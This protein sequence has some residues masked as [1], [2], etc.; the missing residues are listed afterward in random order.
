MLPLRQSAPFDKCCS[1]TAST[2]GYGFL[3]LPCSVKTPGAILYTWLTSLNIG[4]SGSLRRAN[5]LGDVTGISLAEDGMTI[6]G[7]NTARFQSRPEVVSNRLVAEVVSNRRL[8]LRQ[9]IQDFL[10][11]SD[12]RQHPLTSIIAFHIQS[13]KRTS[14]TVQT[15]GK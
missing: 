3:V 12:L 5:S 1:L 10:V 14:K 7:D 4:S 11:G 6:A 8:H 2:L 9:P 13:M 15:C